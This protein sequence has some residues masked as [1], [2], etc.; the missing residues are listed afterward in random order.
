MPALNILGLSCVL[1]FIFALSLMKVCNFI[2]RGG[3]FPLAQ[4]L[5]C[6]GLMP[7]RKAVS[8]AAPAL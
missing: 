8:S 6:A 3:D 1:S 2:E 4:M 7:L 5:K